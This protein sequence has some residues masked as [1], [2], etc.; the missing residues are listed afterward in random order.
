MKS[1]SKLKKE[2]WKL[3]SQYL[4]L[5][6]SKCQVC[7]KPSN[8]VHHI[9]HRARG[10]SVYFHEDNLIVVCYGCH[11]GMHNRFSPDEINKI[12]KK[13]KPN[14]AV[15]EVIKYQKKKFHTWELLEMI[16]NYK[17]KIKELGG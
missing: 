14:F 9:I 12:I 6:Y 11:L 7:G 10:N 8:Q 1:I 16:L 3:V 4:R 13:V 2:L 15:V 17:Q 5:K